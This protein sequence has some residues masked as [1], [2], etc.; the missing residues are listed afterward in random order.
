M[1]PKER[2]EQLLTIKEVMAKTRLS[3][4]TIDRLRK[5]GEFPEPIYIGKRCKRW[6]ESDVDGCIEGRR[7]NG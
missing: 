2:P 4:S 7:S 3:R 5:E 1:T 6:I